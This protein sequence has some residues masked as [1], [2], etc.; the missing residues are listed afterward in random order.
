M[1]QPFKNQ[2][3]GKKTAITTLVQHNFGSPSQSNNAEKEARSNTEREETL[4][5]LADSMIP[6][7]ENLQNQQ[8]VRIRVS[9]FITLTTIEEKI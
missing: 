4:S 9:S 1:L 3:Q 6:Y 5:F 2:E 8:P 7:L